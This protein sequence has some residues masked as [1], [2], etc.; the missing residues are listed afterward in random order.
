MSRRQDRKLEQ[1]KGNALLGYALNFDLDTEANYFRAGN[2]PPA[3][4]F[5]LLSCGFDMALT[6]TDQAFP[7]FDKGAMKTGRKWAREAIAWSGAH[8]GLFMARAAPT[9][10]ARTHGRLGSDAE[11][12]VEAITDP[13]FFLWLKACVKDFFPRARHSASEPDLDTLIEACDAEFVVI[14]EGKP[15]EK[16]KV[17]DGEEPTN[18]HSLALKRGDDPPNDYSLA[19]MRG[20]D[21]R[22]DPELLEA[23]RL[24]ARDYFIYEA[25]LG[26]LQAL[27]FVPDLRRLVDKLILTFDLSD[28]RMS[29]YRQKALAA[30]VEASRPYREYALIEYQSADRSDQPWTQAAKS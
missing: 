20:D 30:W 28:P 17:E 12:S 7:S 1:Q 23:Q 18:P 3:R 13:D 15:R 19:L 25:A 4:A 26:C 8:A 29:E 16:V 22:K 24:Y 11:D 5:Q 14:D 9:L 21:P 10:L 2:S 27:L 6:F